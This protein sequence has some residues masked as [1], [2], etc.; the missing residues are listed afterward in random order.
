MWTSVSPWLELPANV[1][2]DGAAAA[3][4]LEVL[5]PYVGAAAAV[6]GCRLTLSNPS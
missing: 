3:Q 4:H 2:L 6:G 5:A 1:S